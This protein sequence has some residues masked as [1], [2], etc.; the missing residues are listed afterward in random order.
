[1]MHSDSENV[2]NGP[3]FKAAGCF[4]LQCSG[5]GL[6]FYARVDVIANLTLNG[7]CPRLYVSK[8][9]HNLVPI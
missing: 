2:F 1:M 4:D 7:L 8:K 3:A 6:R 9:K 5:S